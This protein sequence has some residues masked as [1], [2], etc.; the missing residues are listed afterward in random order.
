M[1]LNAFTTIKKLL[2]SSL[3]LQLFI[4]LISIPI[5]LSW[6]IPISLLTFAGNV[7]FSPLLTAFL[8]LSSVIFFCELLHIPNGIFIWALEHITHWWLW[9]MQWA[10][11]S[12]LVSFTMPSIFI[13][14]LIFILT[15][16]ILHHKK[17]QTPLKAIA[18]YSIL[19]AITCIYLALPGYSGTKIININ[20]NKGNVHIIKVDKQLIV[21]DPGVIG[22]R[23]SATSWCEY[24]LMPALTK[25]CGTNTIDHLVILQPNRI[26]FEALLNLIEKIRIKNIYIPLWQA[27]MP[28]FWLKS[29]MKLKN[30]CQ[31]NNCNLVRI[32]TQP[33]TID[34]ITITALDE[35]IIVKEFSYPAFQITAA[36]DNQ[37]ISFYS[38]KHKLLEKKDNNGTQ[39]SYAHRS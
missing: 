11:H 6:G 36:I 34:C 9:L 7:L 27:D 20:C 10:G 13:L 5:L 2:I 39:N 4:T 26:I 8:L 19:L 28:S 33:I 21:I 22:R 29:F 30:S 24:T 14:V 3:H 16:L 23:L 32:G 15:L 12:V 31:K 37:S 17:I 35:K 25:N 1:K 38:A 18:Y